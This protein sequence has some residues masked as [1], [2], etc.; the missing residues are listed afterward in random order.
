MM[1]ALRHVLNS[2][3]QTRRRLDDST[4]PELGSGA[5]GG[6]EGGAFVLLEGSGEDAWTADANVN[7]LPDAG[8]P[9]AVT[10]P[11]SGGPSAE[12]WARQLEEMDG[13]DVFSGNGLTELETRHANLLRTHNSLQ[14]ASVGLTRV[15]GAHELDPEDEEDIFQAQGYL[16]FSPQTPRP[17]LPAGAARSPAPSSTQ[18]GPLQAVGLVLK[19]PPPPS[20]SASSSSSSSSDYEGSGSPPQL[21]SNQTL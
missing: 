10:E 16:P 20:S 3:N 18:T 7:D 8:T 6:A 9:S 19:V 2:L 15:G 13:G 21:S 4:L 11:P 12:A 5:G 1:F 14:V 17:K